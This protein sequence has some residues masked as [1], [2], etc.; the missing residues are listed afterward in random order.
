MGSGKSKHADGGGAEGGSGGRRQ[1][2]KREK[3]PKGEKPSSRA[4]PAIP[5][6]HLS[7]LPSDGREDGQDL[8]ADP[9]SPRGLSGA[10]SS[11]AA[12][13]AGSRRANGGDAVAFSTDAN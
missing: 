11:P 10:A 6:T 8:S 12:S 7:S 1:K 3:K 2:K 13:P 5:A 9:R 4:E